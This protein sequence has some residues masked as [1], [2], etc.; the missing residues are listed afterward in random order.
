MVLKNVYKKL[1]EAAYKIEFF[2][3]QQ[4][5]RWKRWNDI[6]IIISLYRSIV[7]L[8]NEAA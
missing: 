2:I 6:T 3:S 1:A 7:N 4:N 8:D 5:Q